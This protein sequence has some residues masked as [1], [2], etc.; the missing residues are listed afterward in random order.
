MR[1][2]WRRRDK[3]G[4]G[5]RARRGRRWRWRSVDRVV[6]R[7]VAASTA[8]QAR[9]CAIHDG[10]CG[11]SPRPASS[12]QA[13]IHRGD[14]VGRS[15]ERAAAAAAAERKAP[16][17]LLARGQRTG[18]R[19]ITARTSAST[20]TTAYSTKVALGGGGGGTATTT[21][22]RAVLHARQRA[23]VHPVRPF[24]DA[25]AVGAGPGDAHCTTCSAGATDTGPAACSKRRERASALPPRKRPRLQQ[26]RVTRQTGAARPGPPAWPQRGW[27][28]GQGPGGSGRSPPSTVARRRGALRARRGRRLPRVREAV[29]A[30]RVSAGGL[31]AGT[32]AALGAGRWRCARRCESKTEVRRC[33]RRRDGPSGFSAR[34]QRRARSAGRRERRRR[35][36]WRRRRWWRRQRWH[37]RCWEPRSRHLW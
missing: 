32:R 11:A 2:P 6:L 33:D 35:P 24:G 18:G 20:S 1:R 9:R 3:W 16:A 4:R 21:A 13:C 37:R 29:P 10:H 14:L 34:R 31:Q 30:R 7:A 27:S 26:V 25:A 15:Q 5:A 36:R 17:A 23:R 19:T 22:G 8:R 28:P 12:C